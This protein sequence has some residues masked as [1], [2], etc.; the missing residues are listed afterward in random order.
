MRAHVLAVARNYTRAFF[1]KYLK[2][3]KSGL[4]DENV[5]D[6]FAESVERF[7]RLNLQT[8]GADR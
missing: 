4:L 7:A 3:T 8:N 2:G 6:R 5:T 1:D